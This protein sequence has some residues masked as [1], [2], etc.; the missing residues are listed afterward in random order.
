MHLTGADHPNRERAQSLLHPF[1]DA[2]ERLVCDAK[3][4]QEILHRYMAIHRREAIGPAFEALS[5]MVDEVFPISESLASG[6]RY[7][8]ADNH[9]LSARDGIHDAVMREHGTATIISSF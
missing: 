1:I 8:L 7:I 9:K 4:F 3:V 6:A 5:G 2:D